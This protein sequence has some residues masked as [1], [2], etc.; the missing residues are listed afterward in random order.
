[1]YSSPIDFQNELCHTDPCR[2]LLWLKKV[3]FSKMSVGMP[4]T[5]KGIPFLSHIT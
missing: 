3:T 4:A 2:I 5:N 1:M